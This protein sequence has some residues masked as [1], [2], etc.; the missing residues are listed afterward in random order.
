MHE[1]CHVDF[2]FFLS[3]HRVKGAGSTESNNP[4]KSSF[5]TLYNL[6]EVWVRDVVQGFPWVRSYPI[7]PWQCHAKCYNDIDLGVFVTDELP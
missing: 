6:G 1:G 2:F 7:S 5:E 3:N 4:G